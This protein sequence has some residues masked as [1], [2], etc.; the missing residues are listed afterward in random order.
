MTGSLL[1]YFLL[2]LV[3]GSFVAADKW[4]RRG[5]FREPSRNFSNSTGS[6]YYPSAGFWAGDAGSS[7]GGGSGGGGGGG[8]E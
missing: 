5:Q 3:L 4:R 6:D 7:W 1:P 8:G 2:A